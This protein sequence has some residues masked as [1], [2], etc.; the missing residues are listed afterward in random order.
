MAAW[1]RDVINPPEL[2]PFSS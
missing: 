2:G 1:V